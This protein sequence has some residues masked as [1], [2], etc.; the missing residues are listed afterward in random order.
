MSYLLPPPGPAPVVIVRDVGG[1]V[2]DYRR[3]TEIFRQEGREV[4]LHECRS[5]CTLALSLPNVCV[6]PASVLRFHQAYNRDTKVVDHGI[7]DELFASYPEAVRRRLGYLTRQ[8]RSL[9]GTELINLGI[10]NCNESPVMFARRKSGQGATQVASAAPKAEE[11]GALSQLAGRLTAVLTGSAARPQAEATPQRPAPMQTAAVPLPAK[12]T[13]KAAPLPPIRPAGLTD[14]TPVATIETD[15]SAAPLPPMRPVRFDA[16][17][18]PPVKMVR[19][20]TF[21]LQARLPDIILG[22]WPVL[23]DG[24]NAFAPVR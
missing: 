7:S 18:P 21:T 1:L 9:S 13:E 4:R 16:P 22:A 17:T 23:P 12:I 10:R 8:Y 6:Y 20:K 15:D 11:P 24:L 2:A 19:T 5:A 3:Q 14:T